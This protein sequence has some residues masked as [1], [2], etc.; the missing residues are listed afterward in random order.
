MVMIYWLVIDANI[1]QLDNVIKVMMWWRKGPASVDLQ[2]TITITS[3]LY[4]KNSF[5]KNIEQLFVGYFTYSVIL[6][7]SSMQ[8]GVELAE[9][10]R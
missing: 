1:L 2:A 8:A 10:T 4:I 5:Y 7:E 9:K 6:L 3:H